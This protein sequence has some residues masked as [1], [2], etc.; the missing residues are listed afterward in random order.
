T[1]G[2]LARWYE[3]PLQRV[4]FATLDVQVWPPSNVAAA[5]SPFAPPFDQRSCCQIPT[6]CLGFWGS[7]ATDGST[8]ALGKRVPP[9]DGPRQESLCQGALPETVTTPGSCA[10]RDELSSQAVQ[11]S[12]RAAARRIPRR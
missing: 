9:P 11:T 6:R 1:H 12:S 4:R 10:G 5:T 2:S 7:T 3:P 8:S